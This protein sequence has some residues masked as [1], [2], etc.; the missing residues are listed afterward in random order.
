VP[1]DP[2]SVGDLTLRISSGVATDD[3]P[4]AT[5]G[6]SSGAAVRPTGDEM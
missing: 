4:R 5:L 6:G 2:A 3:D 1:A